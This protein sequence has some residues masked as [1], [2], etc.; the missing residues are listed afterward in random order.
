MFIGLFN[1]AC[2]NIAV[3]YLKFRDDSTSV[4]QFHTT[5]K[6][7]LPQFSYILRKPEPLGTEF[8]TVA[9]SITGALISLE[10]QWGK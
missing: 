6:G 4:I 3:S 5:L 9:C 1:V 7:D 8:K 10:I 2:L